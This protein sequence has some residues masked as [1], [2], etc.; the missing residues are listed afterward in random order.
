VYY[1]NI[2][3]LYMDN[4]ILIILG[5]I[6]LV[7]IILNHINIIQTITTTSQATCAQTAFG[8]CPDGVNSKINFYGTN[9]PGYR[10]GPGYPNPPPPPGPGPRPPKPI[11]GCAG[12]RYGCCPNNQTPKI[13][14]QGSNCLLK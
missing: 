4:T 14:T 6:L 13:D 5:I 1:F 2:L 9:C 8:C 11:G 3:V 7:L 10:P 12:T